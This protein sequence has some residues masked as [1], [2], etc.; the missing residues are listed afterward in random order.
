MAADVT[1]LTDGSPAFRTVRFVSDVPPA[2]WTL[3][4]QRGPTPVAELLVVADVGTAHGTLVGAVIETG[5]RL[6]LRLR[7]DR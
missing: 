4:E 3:S 7:F 5:F 1:L 2:D 6:A